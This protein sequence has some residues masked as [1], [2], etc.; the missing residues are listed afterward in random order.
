MASY[1]EESLPFGNTDHTYS[2]LE[3]DDGEAAALLSYPS[4]QV[5]EI[6]A[7]GGAWDVWT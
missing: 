3:P 7:A 2:N 6:L 4:D 1:F 5:V